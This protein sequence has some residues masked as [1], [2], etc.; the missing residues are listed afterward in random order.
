MQIGLHQVATPKDHPWAYSPSWR[1]E[2]AKL[3]AD[4]D[5]CTYPGGHDAFIQ[6]QIRFLKIIRQ[7]AH[8]VQLDDK[9]QSEWLP[10]HRAYTLYEGH[11]VSSARVEAMLLCP[12]LTLAQIAT[13]MGP[14]VDPADIK[15]YE[16]LYFNIR[17]DN[18][19][20]LESP[21]LRQYFASGNQVQHNASDYRTH[22]KLLAFEGGYRSLFA[23]WNWPLPETE[24]REALQ[25]EVMTGNVFQDLERRARF[26]ILGN[27]DL[28]E[29]FDSLRPVAAELRLSGRA[30]ARSNRNTL[31]DILSSIKP[32]PLDVTRQSL[33]GKQEELEQKIEVVRRLT[34]GAATGSV[35]E[36]TQIMVSNGAARRQQSSDQEPTLES[37]A[38]PVYD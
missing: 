19:A 5:K 8:Q 27:R 17:D 26:G 20:V 36:Q 37:A 34:T 35:V 23:V 29:L 21:W 31:L 12:E 9:R 2:I 6:Q 14:T 13:N 15:T 28:V 30:G 33:L 32:K 4:A 11:D 25:T 3:T 1:H 16:R 7:R 38:V 18:G 22:W 24:D 10:F